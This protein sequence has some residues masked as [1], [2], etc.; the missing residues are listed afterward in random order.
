MNSIF[1]TGTFGF[2]TVFSTPCDSA[3]EGTTIRGF[4]LIMCSR[5]L[6]KK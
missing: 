5:L 3:S 4:V 6:Q 1:K 2:S